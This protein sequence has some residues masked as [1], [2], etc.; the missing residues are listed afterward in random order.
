[1]KIDTTGNMPIEKTAALK[2]EEL[3][4]ACKE[5][6]TLF[7]YELLKSMRATVDKCDLFHG[8]QGEEIYQSLLDQELSKNMVGSGSNSISNMLY[9]QLKNKLPEAELDKSLENGVGDNNVPDSLLETTISSKSG[10]KKDP[11]TGSDR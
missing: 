4:K 5:F 3:K 11:F 7:T 10:W 1:M 6:E 9:N 8:G 2:N